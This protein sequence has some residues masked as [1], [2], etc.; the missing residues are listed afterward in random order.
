MRGRRRHSIDVRARKSPAPTWL[1]CATMVLG[2]VL[3][4]AASFQA[5]DR[6]TNERIPGPRCWPACGASSKL[7]HRIPACRHGTRNINVIRWPISSLRR[8]CAG[9]VNGHSGTKTGA[10]I[11]QCQIA[12]DCRCWPPWEGQTSGECWRVDTRS[13]STIECKEGLVQPAAISS[14]AEWQKL[15]LADRPRPPILLF[16]TETGIIIKANPSIAHAQ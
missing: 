5:I 11:A 1:A 8:R 14:R 12:I 4:R 9:C 10:A 15:L 7:E 13:V 3:I 6:F 2:F 16:T